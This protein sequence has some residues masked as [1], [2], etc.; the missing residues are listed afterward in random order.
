ML[1][2]LYGLTNNRNAVKLVMSLTVMGSGVVL[3][4]VSIGFIPGGGVPILI[5]EAATVDPVPHS[6]M[7]T[8][9]VINL[10]TTALGL[11]LVL[12]LFKEYSTLDVKEF[13]ERGGD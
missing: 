1:I 9:I 11:A 13:I 6:F 4:F 7:L 10:A 3:L 12:H 8:S 2:G 5:D